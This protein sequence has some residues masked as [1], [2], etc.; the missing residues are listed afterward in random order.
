ML[1]PERIAILAVVG[2]IAVIVVV[3]GAYFSRRQGD[4]LME[5]RLDNLD[6][7][8]ENY[9]SFLQAAE[10]AK[11]QESLSAG[12]VLEESRRILDPINDF[13]A[14]RKFGK[15]WRKKLARANLKLTPAEFA[16]SHVFS[17]GAGFTLG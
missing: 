5:T 2:I 17:M 7:Q 11:Q 6:K 14:E 1:T 8:T 13:L 4:N 10:E 3:L 12:A 15:S 9:E 16:L